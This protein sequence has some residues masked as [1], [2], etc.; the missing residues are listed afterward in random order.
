MTDGA[1]ATGVLTVALWLLPLNTANCADT[2]AVA[3]AV[4]V[5]EVPF[6]GPPLTVAVILLD[7]ANGP[8]VHVLSE[9]MPE[10]SVT[11]VL[12]LGEEIEP[13]PVATAKTMLTPD[14]ALFPASFTIT[15]GAVAT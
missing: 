5:T 8:S 15:D 14:T 12:P 1:V 10:A 2:F 7:P 13:P 9:A 6:S 4:N 3:V 11:T